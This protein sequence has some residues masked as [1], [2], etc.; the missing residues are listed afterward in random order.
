MCGRY[1]I[2]KHVRECD[3]CW[4]LITRVESEPKRALQIALKALCAEQL[5]DFRTTLGRFWWV[6]LLACALVLGVAIGLVILMCR[7]GVLTP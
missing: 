6:T 7:T 4:E 5:I 2:L 1:Q 3:A